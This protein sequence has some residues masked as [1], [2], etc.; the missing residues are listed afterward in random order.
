MEWLPLAAII[1]SVLLIIQTT[2]CI[3]LKADH[4]RWRRKYNELLDDFSEDGK[5]YAEKAERWRKVAYH[6]A[7]NTACKWLREKWPI[8]STGKDNRAMV[9][10]AQQRI[11]NAADTATQGGDDAVQT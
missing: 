6:L 8:L 7:E 10:K 4:D 5:H 9:I 1:V 2:R 11:L 3:Y